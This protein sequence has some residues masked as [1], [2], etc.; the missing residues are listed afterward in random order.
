MRS[1]SLSRVRVAM[2]AGTLQPKPIS[3]GMKDL[4]CSPIKCMM[5]S[6]RKAERAM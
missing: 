2:M 3:M 4:P 5:R 6:I 1:F